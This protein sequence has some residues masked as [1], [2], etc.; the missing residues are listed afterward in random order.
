MHLAATHPFIASLQHI[1]GFILV[2]LVLLTLWGLTVLIGRIF[3]RFEAASAP[4]AAAPEK[5]APAAAVESEGM[6]E[7]EIAAIAAVVSL[8][9]G[10]RSRIVSIRSTTKDWSREG[11][12]EHFASHRLR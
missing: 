10:R 12:R 8:F 6:P 1:L 5:N 4:K 2:V 9:M 11:R 3:I 7:E